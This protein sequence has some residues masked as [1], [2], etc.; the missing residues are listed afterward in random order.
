MPVGRNQLGMGYAST[1]QDSPGNHADADNLPFQG[2]RGGLPCFSCKTCSSL[3]QRG[4]GQR[5]CGFL[6]ER[7]E[8]LVK[9]TSRIPP[10]Y[11]DR[12]RLEAST[13]KIAMKHPN[14]CWHD[15]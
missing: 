5:N 3:G 10:C 9:V 1:H 14:G 4:D 8:R 2:N 7:R 6:T 11:L 15:W 12:E 13:G